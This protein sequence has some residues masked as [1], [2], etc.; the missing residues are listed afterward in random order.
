MESATQPGRHAFPQL[1]GKRYSVTV[2]RKFVFSRIIFAS[3]SVTLRP[4]RRSQEH[5]IKLT[6]AFT[7]SRRA[8]CG[9]FGYVGSDDPTEATSAQCTH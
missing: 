4:P 8:Q 2:V 3:L 5:S 9:G 1:K 6:C 7:L